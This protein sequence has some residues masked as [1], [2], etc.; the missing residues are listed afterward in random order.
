LGGASGSGVLGQG[1]PLRLLAP[2]VAVLIGERIKLIFNS[3]RN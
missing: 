2:V 1:E 3:R